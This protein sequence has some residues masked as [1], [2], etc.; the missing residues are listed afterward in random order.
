MI[1]EL[2]S[3]LESLGGGA[4][5]GFI[6]VAFTFT[7]MLTRP[8]SGKLSDTIGRK[9]VIFIG[10]FV[11]FICGL[12]YPVLNFMLG[13]LCL[14]LLNGLATGFAPTGTSTYIA[15]IVPPARVGEAMGVLGLIS[16][17]GTAIAPYMGS[18]I[19]KLKDYGGLNL[20]FYTSSM[21]AV[22]AMLLILTLPESLPDRQKFTWSLLRL[23]KAELAERSAFPPS[24]I[25]FFSVYAFG[26]VLTTMPDFSLSLGFQNKG[27]F[28]MYYTLSSLGIR[29]VAGKLSDVYG[30]V[31]M[32]RVGLLV[33][34]IALAYLAYA[35]TWV[36]VM[37]GGILY[38]ISVGINS[39]TLFAWT[40]DLCPTETRGKAI[41]TIFIALEAGIL[42]GALLT[43]YMYAND[44]ANITTVYLVA[45]LFALAAW[46]YLQFVVCRQAQK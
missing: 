9:P 12:L 42:M 7:A 19:A 36:D 30:R 10:L 17:I 1:A 6:F 43:N 20:M 22:I 24:L 35:K 32:L 27:M 25:M 15:D 26:V 41:A 14:R 31:V 29:F 38:G 16:N 33:L 28:F 45:M 5:K 46:A 21:L 39:P 34:A 37:I 4:Y 8:I 11:S 13:F 18:E 23:H 3:Y 44:L 40:I 2:P